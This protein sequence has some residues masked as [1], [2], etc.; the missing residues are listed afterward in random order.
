MP[1]PYPVRFLARSGSSYN[2]V[3]HEASSTLG[4]RKASAYD[5]GDELT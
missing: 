1:V 2:T 4:T 5:R 3:V